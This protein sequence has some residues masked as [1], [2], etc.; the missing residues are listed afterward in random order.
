MPVLIPINAFIMVIGNYVIVEFSQRANA[1]YRYD[2]HSSPIGGTQH[3]FTMSQL[4]RRDLAKRMV[5]N[6][7]QGLTWQQRFARELDLNSD[8]H[9]ATSARSPNGRVT[10]RGADQ[11][12][13]QRSTL[14]QPS[15]GPTRARVAAVSPSIDDVSR[16]AYR[17]GLRWDNHRER[18]GNVWVYTRD[19]DPQISSQLK[20]WSFIYKHNKGWWRE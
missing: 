16:F 10:D 13:R 2:L 11:G 9:S 20:A 8:A 7:A 19:D 12:W 1:A 17:H 3:V 5:H 4:K 6:T 18:G 15:P 14:H